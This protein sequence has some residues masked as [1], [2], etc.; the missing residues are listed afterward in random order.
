MHFIMEVVHAT[1][2]VTIIRN[3]IKSSR[4]QAEGLWQKLKYLDIF[5][6]RRRRTRAGLTQVSCSAGNT[7][8]R[9]IPKY[10]L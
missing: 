7:V 5:P 6:V 4:G 1:N 2:L 8:F 3:N 10:S 9:V